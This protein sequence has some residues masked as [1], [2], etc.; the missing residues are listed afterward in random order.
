MIH[1]CRPLLLLLAIFLANATPC[2]ADITLH[3]N[4][5]TQIAVPSSANV[6][7]RFAIEDFITTIERMTDVRLTTVNYGDEH[8][9]SSLPA[10]VVIGKLPPSIALPPLS[11]S[12]ESTF[13]IATDSDKLYINGTT[14]DAIRHGLYFFLQQFGGVRWFQPGSDYESIP[15]R[16]P[17]EIGDI[18]LVKAPDTVSVEFYGLRTDEEKLWG[19]RNLIRPT[20]AFHHNLST[21]FTNEVM[22]SH[23]EW[24]SRLD[25]KTPQYTLGG[26]SAQPHLLA[27]GVID[28]SAEAANSYFKKNPDRWSFSLGINDSVDFDTGARSESLALPLKFF[29]KRPNLSDIV[30]TYMNV[31]SNKLHEYTPKRYLGCLAYFTC[32]LPPTTGIDSRVIP[33]LTLDSAQW[34]NSEWRE[35]DKK[36]MHDWALAGADHLGFYD[37]QDSQAFYVPRVTLKNK[38]E[39]LWH[40]QALGY[41]GYFLELDP[42]WSFD[43]PL[44]W[45]LATQSCN[46]NVDT[47]Q[48]LEDYYKTLYGNAANSMRTFADTLESCWNQRQGE[49]TWIKYY[50]HPAQARI[51]PAETRSKITALLRQAYNEARID[52]QKKRI[53]NIRSAWKTAV[54]AATFY[55]SF[56]DLTFATNTEAEAIK[57]FDRL[58]EQLNNEPRNQ[59]INLLLACDPHGTLAEK[60]GETC[61]GENLLLNAELKPGNSEQTMTYALNPIPIIPHWDVIRT[62]DDTTRVLSTP[63]GSLMLEGCTHLALSQN[64]KTISP[65]SIYRLRMKANGR[66]NEGA[67]VTACIQY[68]DSKGNLLPNEYK[69]I[70]L[71][72]ETLPDGITYA[73]DL[74]APDET[75]NARTII[76]IQ[77]QDTTSRLFIKAIEVRMK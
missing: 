37:Y 47:N 49:P 41:S 14:S 24:A 2:L 62:P 1:T 11:L 21:I 22:R 6:S 30:F 66:L 57:A 69:H 77:G 4:A 39:A 75:A 35:T 76:R 25:H 36:L 64:I 12:T 40:S 65:S 19:Q 74:T 70:F 15:I 45:I 20:I 26:N 54:L 38:I 29:R 23:P 56:R 60:N 16:K 46:K 44:A 52:I 27:E 13:A 17:W 10:S 43:G 18:R 33:Y 31:V 71:P 58:R 48:L 7:L 8:D 34:S 73:V 67:R 5:I 72:D 55:E 59:A 51:Y 50:L 28:L 32:E 61:Q 3:G 9:S 63:D 42:N 68:F 53:E